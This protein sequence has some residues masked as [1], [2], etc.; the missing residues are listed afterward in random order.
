MIFDAGYAYKRWMVRSIA[1]AVL[2]RPV[3]RTTSVLW[4]AQ[5]AKI[6]SW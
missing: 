5:V 6:V 2:P 4:L 1:I 3:G